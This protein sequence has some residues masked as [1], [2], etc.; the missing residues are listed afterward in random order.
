MRFRWINVVLTIAGLVLLAS[1][2]LAQTA[3][4]TS[5]SELEQSEAFR[6]TL[7]R[8]QIKREEAEHKKRLDKASQIR[9]LASSLLRDSEDGS[10]RHSAD[11]KLRDIEKAARSIRSELGGSNDETPLEAPPDTLSKAVHQM[12]TLSGQFS[13]SLEKTSRQVVSAAVLAEATEIIQL[14][15]IIRG[16]LN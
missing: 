3:N 6:D 10:L 1:L 16:F 12:D 7:V 15:K 14:V 8:M 5:S 2:T 9:D 13:S 4:P 11:K